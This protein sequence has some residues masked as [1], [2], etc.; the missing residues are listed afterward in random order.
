MRSL[1][2]AHSLVHNPTFHKVF[3]ERELLPSINV[4]LNVELLHISMYVLFQ[5]HV[6][7]FCHYTSF[8]ASDFR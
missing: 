1:R 4:L 7:P 5:M 2:Q 8:Y 3:D 6:V